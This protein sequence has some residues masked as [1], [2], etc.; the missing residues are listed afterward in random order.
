MRATLDLLVGFLSSLYVLAWYLDPLGES[1]FITAGLPYV[2]DLLVG[3]LFWPV[4]LRNFA[5][6]RMKA[7]HCE[8]YHHVVHVLLGGV[9]NHH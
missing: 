5:Q 2:L 3:F 9:Q 7:Y 6:D 4:N 8:C 1:N